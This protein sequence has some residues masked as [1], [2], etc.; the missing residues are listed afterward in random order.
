MTN[1]KSL[2]VSAACLWRN[3]LLDV[4]F[5]DA[6]RLFVALQRETQGVPQP[7]R[8]VKIRDDALGNIDGLS[9]DA[10]RLRIQREIDDQ[11]FGSARHAAEIR[12]ASDGLRIIDFDLLVL[13]LYGWINIRRQSLFAFARSFSTQDNLPTM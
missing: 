10:D 7:L 8:G 13:L 3:A 4:R 2:L 12:V 6:E 9:R 5:Q 11:L 1:D